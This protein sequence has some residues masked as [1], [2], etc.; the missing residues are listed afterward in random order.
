[1]MSQ[2][3]INAQPTGPGTVDH[4]DAKCMLQA[5]DHT[6][7]EHEGQQA[8]VRKKASCEVAGYTHTLPLDPQ[9]RCALAHSHL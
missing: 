4:C 2:G 6:V 5:A 9:G 3:V 8:V 7:G 1:M